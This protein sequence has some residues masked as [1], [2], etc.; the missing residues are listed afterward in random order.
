MNKWKQV[1]KNEYLSIYQS[2]FL[3]KCLNN[4][5]RQRWNTNTGE[6]VHPIISNRWRRGRCFTRGFLLPTHSRL[7]SPHLSLTHIALP[8]VTSPHLTTSSHV[9]VPLYLISYHI[10]STNLTLSQLTSLYLQSLHNHHLALSS[11]LTPC[12]ISSPRHLT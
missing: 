4:I 8:H 11:H 1:Q 12:K 9:I 6:A 2:I 5:A 7:A 3:Y 10:K